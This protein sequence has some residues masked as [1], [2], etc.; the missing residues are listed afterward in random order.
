[1]RVRGAAADPGENVAVRASPI[2]DPRMAARGE[3]VQGRRLRRRFHALV[4]LAAV[5]VLVVAAWGA[6]R[7]PL[8]ALRRTVVQ[9]PTGART[10][11][12]E[13]MF[14]AGLSHRIPMAELDVNAIAHRVARLPWV[15]SVS[16]ARHWPDT[17]TISFSERRAAAQVAGVGGRWFQVDS[18]GRILETRLS[19]SPDLVIVGGPLVAGTPGMGLSRSW[20]APV[21]LANQLP[22]SLRTVVSSVRAVRGDLQVV[23]ANGG[24]IRLCGDDHLA[25]K[26]VATS[27]MLANVDPNLV[28]AI[29]VCVPSAPA[30]LPRPPPPSPADSSPSPS[31][32]PVAQ[33]A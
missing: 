13:V 5:L 9:V 18:S 12:A 32:T 22:A 27:T 29:D 2:I 14:V 8:L 21:A 24:T 19:P 1:M 15:D 10:T 16:V 11:R 28:G 33:G 23:L 17:V 26:L 6:A 7:S 30:L 4:T 25:A 20:W 3:E 31:L